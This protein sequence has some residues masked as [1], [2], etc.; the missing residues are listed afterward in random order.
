MVRR[1]VL[2]T[3]SDRHLCPIPSSFPLLWRPILMLGN[4]HSVRFSLVASDSLQVFVFIII[5][6]TLRHVSLSLNRTPVVSDPCSS[7][8]S[9]VESFHSSYLAAF[10]LR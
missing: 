1:D 7:S 9:D 10:N 6:R 4:G 3:E 2:I 8:L 5:T